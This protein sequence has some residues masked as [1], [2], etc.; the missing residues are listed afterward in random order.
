MYIG[1]FWN[2]EPTTNS[3]SLFNRRNMKPLISTTALND[4]QFPYGDWRDLCS[5]NLDDFMSGPKSLLKVDCTTENF[6]KNKASR[7]KSTTSTN[8]SETS[9][10]EISSKNVKIFTF[11]RVK[12]VKLGSLNSTNST[13]SDKCN[14]TL[15]ND[16]TVKSCSLRRDV[17]NKSMVRQFH[18]FTQKLFHN[19]GEDSKSNKRSA[20]RFFSGRTQAITEKTINELIQKVINFCIKNDIITGHSVN[21]SLDALSTK[22][23]EVVG[24]LLWCGTHQLKV[25]NSIKEILSANC[26]FSITDNLFINNSAVTTLDEILKKYTHTRLQKVFENPILCKVLKHFLEQEK[27]SFIGKMECADKKKWYEQAFAD[28]AL[29]MHPTELTN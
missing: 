3:E 14:E 12:K 8:S 21:T 4:F 23:Q 1:L 11:E 18:R 28:F 2:T 29:N 10:P 6:W 27:D 22:D 20:K 24:L 25:Y 15:E 17:V 9:S 19:C 26:I 7:K 16:K 5:E 13:D